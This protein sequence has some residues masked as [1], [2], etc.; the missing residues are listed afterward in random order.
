MNYPDYGKSLLYQLDQYQGMT[1][2][3]KFVLHHRISLA[4]KGRHQG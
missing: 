1:T 4:C 3:Q 2:H